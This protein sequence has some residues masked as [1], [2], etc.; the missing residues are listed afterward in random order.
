MKWNCRADPPV[1]ASPS[2]LYYVHDPMCSWCWAYRPVLQRLREHLPVEIRWQ[3]VLGGLAPDSDQ[4]MP[5]ATRQMVQGH[6][7]QIQSSVGTRFNFD[8]W[9][10]CQPRRDTY[11]ACRAVIAA[12]FQAAEERMIQAIQEAYYLRAMNPSEPATLAELA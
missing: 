2:V 5:G 6:W 8:F 3:N 7:R 11:K 4:P 9:S 12:S 1:P 10:R